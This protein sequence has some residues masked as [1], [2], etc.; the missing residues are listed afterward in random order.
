MG[1]DPILAENTKKRPCWLFPR[2]NSPQV[3]LRYDVMSPPAH[4][5]L[6]STSCKVMRPQAPCSPL[7]QPLRELVPVTGQEPGDKD[8]GHQHTAAPAAAAATVT[9]SSVTDPESRG[10]GAA[11]PVT[12]SWVKAHTSHGLDRLHQPLQRRDREF[13]QTVH[14][15]LMQ[16]AKG[17][18]VICAGNRPK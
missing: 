2:L 7:R 4:S 5:R 9:A 3:T 10:T 14:T 13:H 16:R 8:S 11:A 17:V 18:T 1:E 6:P 15:R 12:P